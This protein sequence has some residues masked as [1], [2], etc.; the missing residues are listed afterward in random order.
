MGGVTGSRLVIVTLLLLA[1]LAGRAELTCRATVDRDEVAPGGQVVL[2]LEASTD[3]GD[4]PRHTRPRIAGVEVVPGGSSQSVRMTNGRTEHTVAVTYYLV[5][6]GDEDVRIPAIE[7]T[8]RDERCRTD[9]IDIR[10]RAAAS[11]RAPRGAPPATAPDGRGGPAARGSG[12]QAGRSGDAYFITLTVDRDE[13]WV[14]Q[15]VVATF[16]FHRRRNPWN[17][18]SYTAPRTEGFWRVDLPPERNYRTTIGGTVYDIT[19]IRYALFPTRAG[20]LQIEPARLEIAGDPFDRLLGRRGRGT[21]RL[22]TDPIPITVEDL[23]TPR[24]AAFSGL[25]ADR[26]RFTATVD[27]DTVPRGEPLALR[28]AVEA[29]GFL[30]SFEGVPLPE[31]DGVQLHDASENYREDVS[32]PRY[33][34]TFAQEKAVV[35][36]EEGT[37]DLPPLELVYFDTGQGRYATAST[38]LPA[39]VV[40][41]SDRPVV[42]DDPS[43]FRRTEIERLGNDLAFIH[44]LTGPAEGRRLPAVGGAVWWSVLIV[45]WIVLAIERWRLRRADAARRDPV[46]QRRRRALGNARRLLDAAARDGDVDELA[47]AI[48]TFVADRTGRTPAAITASDVGRLA[49]MAG[50]RDA[51][52][53]LVSILETCDQAR[54]GGQDRPDVATLAAEARRQLPRLVT[55]ERSAPAETAARLVLLAVL[56][57][58]AGEAALAQPAAS[59]PGVDPARLIAEGNEAYTDGDLEL[60]LRRYREAR[61]LGADAATLHYNLGNTYARRGELGRAIASYE[62]ALRRT[63]RDGDVRRNL[64]WV[65]SHTRDLELAGQGLPPVI[66]QLDRAAHWLSVREW[67][68]GLVVLSWLLAGA[69]AWSWRR[70]E[71]DGGWRRLVIAAAVGWL[72]VA[73]V[74]ATRWY[75]EEWREAAVV[76]V[77]EVEV[78]SGPATTFGVVFRIHDGLALTVRGERDGWSRIGLGGD[79]VGWVPSGT[80]ERVDQGR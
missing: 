59:A 79:W 80:L 51:G 38:R 36:L 19:E 65:R 32:G 50:S 29:D 69:V 35:P 14:G 74:T 46:G 49:A 10:V 28:L 4:Q 22:E 9:P 54:F 45:P 25:V 48:R 12:P 78:R 33:Q 24:P 8:T 63:P 5:V 1:P 70:A 20:D 72:A 44:P 60:A 13:V 39:V 11:R 76:V 15:Q 75:E 73:L 62:R 3:A 21:V 64:A 27:R 43:G 40:T 6:R 68:L 57:L 26:V 55:A 30:K 66:A 67:G 52:D 41:P 47:R 16:R 37:L 23:P 34:A 31:P 61:D 71:M 56:V 58:P 7:F 77:D 53:R 17:Q 42:G 18:P 2:T